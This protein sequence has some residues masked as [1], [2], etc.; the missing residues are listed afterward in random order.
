MFDIA[1]GRTARR[2]FCTLVLVGMMLATTGIASA[3][4]P[5]LSEK[6]KS[7]VI[8]GIVIKLR[9]LYVD[10]GTDRKTLEK[11]LRDKAKRGGYRELKTGDEFARELETDLQTLGRDMHF[12]ATYYPNGV[13]P[14]PTSIVPTKERL[15]ANRVL[16]ATAYNNGF[17][18][19]SRIDGNIGVIEMNAIPDVEF[20]KDSAAA[21]L[22][23]VMHTDALILDLRRARGGE[24]RGISYF[25]SYFL[26][27]RVHTFDMVP[28]KAEERM[29]F[30]TEETLPGPRYAASKP[31]YVLTGGETFSGGEAL[32]YSLQAFKRARVIGEK[33]RGG[34][35]AAMPVKV[36]EHFAAG[37]PFMATISAATGTN[38]NNV[39][40]IPDTEVPAA[41]ARD[42][43][44]REA[45]EHILANEKDPARQERIRGW[46][47]TPR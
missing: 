21:A 45:L 5:A 10:S 36:S 26:P 40:V 28:V 39:G 18:A 24:P 46:L 43:A 16:F 6:E 31:I 34:S 37:I 41:Q 3:A 29:V 19:V 14:L 32:A 11:A 13:P 33:S 12:R 38:W 17:T 2:G 47:R 8:D 30:H 35:T 20:I 1:C 9:E 23:L 27:G 22:T 15:E 25:L 4:G 42:A 44:Q 7:E